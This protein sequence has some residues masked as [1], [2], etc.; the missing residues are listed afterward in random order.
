MRHL[1]LDDPVLVCGSFKSLY[2]NC[3]VA[4]TAA[5]RIERNLKFAEQIGL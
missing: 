3:V 2:L 1:L 4:E 5:N